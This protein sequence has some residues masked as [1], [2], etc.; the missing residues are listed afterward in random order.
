MWYA[1]LDGTCKPAYHRIG[2]IDTPDDEHLVARNI[3]RNGINKYKIKNCASSW[4]FTKN[5]IRC[6]VNKT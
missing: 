5:V 6:T 3:Q 4:L 1:G 2:T